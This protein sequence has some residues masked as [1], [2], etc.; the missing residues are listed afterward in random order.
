M[1]SISNNLFISEFTGLGQM[2]GFLQI[3]VLI[4]DH[5]PELDGANDVGPGE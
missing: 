4:G 1:F 3:R 5:V 2:S